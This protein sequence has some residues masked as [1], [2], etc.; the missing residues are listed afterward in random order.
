[1]HVF[2]IAPLRPRASRGTFEKQPYAAAFKKWTWGELNSRVERSLPIVYVCIYSRITQLRIKL[3][4]AGVLSSYRI[5]ET[6]QYV[7]CCACRCDSYL[8]RSHPSRLI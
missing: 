8:D 2:S 1:M 7:R 4:W 5:E 3:R 6:I